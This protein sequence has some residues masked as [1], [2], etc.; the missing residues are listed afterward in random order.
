VNQLK[1]FR[2]PHEA[3]YGEIADLALPFRLRL[4]LTD[5]NRTDNRNTRIYNNTATRALKVFQSGLMTAS[6]DPTS[7][8]FGLT[9]KDQDRAE[10][11]PHRV[12]LDEVTDQ[13]LDVIA[14][15]NIYQRLPVAYGNEAC[16]GMFALGLEESFKRSAIHSRL[17]PHG[18]YWVGDDDEGNACVFYREYRATLRQL[19]MRFPEGQWSKHVQDLMD[20]GNWE[21]WV[22]VAQL[23]EP[24][25]DYQEGNPHWRRKRFSSCW[26]EIGESSKGE[27]TDGAND[28]RYIH[29]GGFDD[30]PVLVGRWEKVESE[31][32]PTDYPGS[33]CLGD[34]KSLQVGEK[35]AAQLIEK[36]V[37]PHMIAPAGMRGQMDPGQLP[38]RWSWVDERNEGKSVRPLY[39]MDPSG[40]APM[41][42]QLTNLEKRILESFHYS[43]FSTFDALPDKQRTATEIL[44][45]KSEKLLKLVD[46]AQN[47]QMDVH[48]PMVFQIFS[49]LDRRGEI[50][51][52]PE[53]L[54]GHVLDLRFNGVLA[55]AQ[56]MNR[57]QP[58]QFTANWVAEIAKLQGA[59]GTYP[60]VMDKFNM[61]QAIDVVASD[62]NCPAT[63]VR[64]DDEVAAIRAERQKAQQAQ[65]MMQ[66]G[67]AIA[68]T[69]KDLAA[70]DMEGENALTKLVG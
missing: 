38:G 67:P 53:G 57:V 9:I 63:V 13:I 25:D 2:L 69:A 10:Y 3:T 47:N 37:N 28:E 4:Q 21:E 16:F 18:S 20:K 17:Y 1:A 23:I 39:Q 66:A 19:Y 56:K 36:F 50:R 58:V 15:S 14:E 60:D 31:V 44:E 34:N 48:R 35:R 41:R 52:A 70:A 65:Q 59:A 30:F 46:M 6:T 29:E 33:E 40:I 68:K 43:T 45:R 42:E 27:Y 7:R 61:D 11:G 55:Q 8:W 26:Y 5:Y 54:Q 24:N 22:D 12:W 32:Y 49:I 64:S 62:M 51:P